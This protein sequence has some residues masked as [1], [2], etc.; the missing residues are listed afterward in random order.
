[1]ATQAVDLLASVL[2]IK[3]SGICAA[4]PSTAT[5]STTLPGGKMRPESS[6]AAGTAR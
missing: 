3:S 6:A 1:M 5:A 4:K 2:N